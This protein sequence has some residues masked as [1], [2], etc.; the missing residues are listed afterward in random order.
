MRALQGSR[1]ATSPYIDRAVAVG[2]K[3][4]A[5]GLDILRNSE[6]FS[7]PFRVGAGARGSREFLVLTVEIVTLAGPCFS[8]F[9]YVCVND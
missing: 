1:S 8:I 2:N 3:T 9:G 7:L 4:G 5:H 6:L